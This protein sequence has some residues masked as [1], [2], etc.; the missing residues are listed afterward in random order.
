MQNIA[1]I[2]QNISNRNA[3]CKEQKLCEMH[4]EIEFKLSKCH[5]VRK[6]T[7]RMIDE[8]AKMV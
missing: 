6:K 2:T 4:K 1:E 7:V 3:Q 5:K 8:R